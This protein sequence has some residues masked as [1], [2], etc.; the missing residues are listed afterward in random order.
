MTIVLI[1]PGPSDAGALEILTKRILHPAR[2][3]VI[4]IPM[5]GDTKVKDANR[6]K[7]LIE[8]DPRLKKHSAK[9]AIAC[10]DFECTGKSESDQQTRAIQSALRNLVPSV[11]CCPMIHALEGWLLADREAVAAYLGLCQQKIPLSA[12]SDCRPKERMQALFRKFG[13]RYNERAHA[14]EIA[15]KVDPNRIARNN[16]SFQTFID[17]IKDP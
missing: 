14:P 4:A 11:K 17:A 15:D 1:V 13:K 8:G 3:R 6:I 16:P 10:M 9:R 7:R 5:R 2:V 12:S